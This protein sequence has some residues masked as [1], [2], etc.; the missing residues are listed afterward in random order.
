MESPRWRP[1]NGT[2]LGNRRGNGT[3]G[4]RWPMDIADELKKLQ[5]LHESGALNDEEFARAKQLVL[6][7]TT[8]ARAGSSEGEDLV[9]SLFGGKK[10]T[11]GDAANRYVN[12]R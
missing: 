7:G 11:L 12:F 9:G 6:N 3:T 1:V 8:P 10:E 2:T 4:T 5:Q